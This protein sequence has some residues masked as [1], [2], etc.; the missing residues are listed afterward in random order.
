ML[1]VLF[2]KF[3]C[4]FRCGQNVASV[5]VN[6]FV[7]DD[8]MLFYGLLPVLYS[9][10]TARLL[11]RIASIG[12]RKGQCAQVQEVATKDVTFLRLPGCGTFRNQV[13]FV[14]SA[15]SGETL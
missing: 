3:H 12:E 4:Q 5:V 6:V 14:R 13:H 8:A 7:G 10:I 9:E 1:V 15:S 11:Q 2:E